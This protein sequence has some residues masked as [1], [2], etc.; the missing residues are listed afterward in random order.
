MIK[1]KPN[2]YSLKFTLSVSVVASVISF[3]L[4]FSPLLK[5]DFIVDSQDTEFTDNFED[6]EQELDFEILFISNKS[7]DY[8]EY[9]I[10]QVFVYV[11]LKDEIDSNLFSCLISPPPK[12]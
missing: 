9:K 11:S 10:S 1:R 8:S 6:S 12:L 7:L 3:V 2:K 5:L 4:V